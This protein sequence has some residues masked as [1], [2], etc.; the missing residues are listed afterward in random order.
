MIP[1]LNKVVTL[2]NPKANKTKLS[3]NLLLKLLKRLR[4][5]KM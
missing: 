1:D 4:R 3:R 2:A 5:K